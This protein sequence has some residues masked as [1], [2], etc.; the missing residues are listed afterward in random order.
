[1]SRRRDRILRLSLIPA[2]VAVLGGL[3][4][5]ES[6]DKELTAEVGEGLF[7][8]FLLWG[9]VLLM[10]SWGLF[11]RSW[12]KVRWTVPWRVALVAA[13][14]VVALDVVISIVRVSADSGTGP[15]DWLSLPVLVACG[16]IPLSLLVGSGAPVAKA[17]GEPP[18]S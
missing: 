5:A 13:A 18:L 8:R 3:V 4:W 9:W 14:W 1:M 2:T 7:V 17:N 10:L 6:L 15:A 11:S 16:V 12:R